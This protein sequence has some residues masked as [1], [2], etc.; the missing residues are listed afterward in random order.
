MLFSWIDSMGLDF[1]VLISVQ[2]EPFLFF[3]FVSFG[4]NGNYVFFLLLSL[5][6]LIVCASTIWSRDSWSHLWHLI[7]DYESTFSP[8][9]WVLMMRLFKQHY[10]PLFT[11][12]FFLMK[13][14]TI[15]AIVCMYV[16]VSTSRLRFDNLHFMPPSSTRL[17][18]FFHYTLFVFFSFFLCL[19][20]KFKSS[21]S[22]GRRWRLHFSFNSFWWLV[23]FKLG[24]CK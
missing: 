17:H 21:S 22:F 19:R 15:C 4:I 8:V 16:C 2:F 11:L 24:I 5:T 10:F 14:L 13:D 20:L 3:F 18:I 1:L 6:L 9:F 7:Y 12:S 23:A